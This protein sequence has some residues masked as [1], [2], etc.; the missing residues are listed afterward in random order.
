MLDKI[1]LRLLQNLSLGGEEIRLFHRAFEE[2]AFQVNKKGWLSLQQE[3]EKAK[4]NDL[5]S[6]SALCN[7]ALSAARLSEQIKVLARVKSS[8]LKNRATITG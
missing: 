5:N 7:T 4:L 3:E 8:H 1:S 6:I 2:E